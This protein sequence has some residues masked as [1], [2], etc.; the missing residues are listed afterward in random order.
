M[1]ESGNNI[2]QSCFLET[3]LSLQIS[4]GYWYFLSNEGAESSVIHSLEKP[5]LL[6]TGT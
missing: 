4:W 6:H 5:K 3:Y 1:V 2:F